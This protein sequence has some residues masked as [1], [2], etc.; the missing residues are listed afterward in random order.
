MVRG[1]CARFQTPVVDMGSPSPVLAH[2]NPLF[3]QLE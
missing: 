1:I 2:D 3:G